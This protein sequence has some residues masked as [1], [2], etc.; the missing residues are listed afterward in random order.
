MQHRSNDSTRMAVQAVSELSRNDTRESGGS[1]VAAVAASLTGM[2]TAAISLSAVNA[3]PSSLRE[4]LAP[5]V[6]SGNRGEDVVLSDSKVAIVATPAVAAPPRATAT[7]KTNLDA[8]TTREPSTLVLREGPDATSF[9]AAFA[10][11]VP[12]LPAGAPLLPSVPTI[13]AQTATGGGGGNS[14]HGNRLTLLVSK[15]QKGN[16]VLAH[17]K[18]VWWEFADVVP[19]YVLGATTG[20]VFLSLR[21]HALHPNHV[22]RRLKE[23]ATV[24]AIT[25]RIVLVLAD[26]DDVARPLLDVTRQALAGAATVVVASSAQEA[27]RYLETFKTYEHK[28]ATAIRERIGT[29]Y[30]SIAS[31]LLTSVRSV[32]KTD[33]LTLLSTFGS[34]AAVM[35][36]SRAELEACPGFGDKKVARLWEALHGNMS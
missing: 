18:C 6:T 28:P 24:S 26:I 12:A 23:L 22:Y 16:P 31:E 19:D 34:V 21:Y 8:A 4:T 30:L 5:A 2:D 13:A 35:R 11:R 3:P 7:A 25:L 29:G 17:L 36:A 20:A 27:A 33:V 1:P 32:N 14:A 15:K 9:A 10:G